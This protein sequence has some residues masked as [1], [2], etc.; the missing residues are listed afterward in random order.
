MRIY[1]ITRL[2]TY[3]LTYS[4]THSFPLPHTNHPPTESESALA[5]VET[6]GDMMCFRY[7]AGIPVVTIRITTSLI[8]ADQALVSMRRELPLSR[9]FDDIATEARAEWNQL[10]RRVDVVDPGST[11][12][13]ADQQKH[14]TVFYTGLARALSFPRKLQEVDASGR[15][16]HYR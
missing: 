10:L 6:N 3:S 5:E 9:G 14:L 2:L 8:S 4:L 1:T 7:K 12:Y 16:L 11:E 15:V 13:A